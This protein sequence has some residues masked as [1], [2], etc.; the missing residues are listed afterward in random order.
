MELSEEEKK[1]IRRA[2]DKVKP[3]DEEPLR[4]EYAE[5]WGSIGKTLL[6]SRF[7]AVRDLALNVASLWEMLVDP[8]YTVAWPTKAK[9][10]F[11]LGYFVS[12][13]DLI[14][15]GIPVAGFLDDA[16]VV[17]Y[18]VHLLTADISKYRESRRTSG[19]PLPF[20]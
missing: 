3:E 11:A 6:N 17:G 16:L 4:R 13:A 7:K 5:K 8:D 12:P 1:E 10:I 15:D 18:I 20:P 19:R 14:P 9:I 2:C